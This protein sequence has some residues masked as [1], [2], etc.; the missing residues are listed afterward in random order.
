MGMKPKKKIIYGWVVDW[1]DK[2]GSRITIDLFFSSPRVLTDCCSW[3]DWKNE[4]FVKVEVPSE[5]DDL[6]YVPDNY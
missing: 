5:F 3:M 4:Q 2:K 6:D 1:G